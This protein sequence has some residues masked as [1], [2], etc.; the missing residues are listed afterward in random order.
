MVK[1]P[2]TKG[3]KVLLLKPLT[4]D[5]GEYGSCPCRQRLEPKCNLP[6]PSH[7][8]SSGTAFQ[9]EWGPP[10]LL[11]AFLKQCLDL[12]EETRK[13]ISLQAVTR[14]AT[15]PAPAVSEAGTG[16]PDS[17]CSSSLLMSLMMARKKGLW[18]GS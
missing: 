10:L 9:S 11:A 6:L 2:L 16:W 17:L 18:L 3:I 7:E 13:Q 14:T 12:S 5:K 15:L 1:C 4:K 8:S